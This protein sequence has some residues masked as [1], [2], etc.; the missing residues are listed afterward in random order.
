MKM[1]GGG[2]KIR[3]PTRLNAVALERVNASVIES[4]RVSSLG[5]SIEE[6]QTQKRALLNS[7]FAGRESSSACEIL[8]SQ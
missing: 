3:L 2:V 8:C 7:C 5:D 4:S 6:E 1:F